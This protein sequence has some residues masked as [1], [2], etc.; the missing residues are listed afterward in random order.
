M[1]YADDEKRA[2]QD[3]KA[4][5]VIRESTSPW[6]SPIVLV[7]MKDGGLR[8]CVDNHKVDELDKPDRFLLP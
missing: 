6:A 4:K 2:I 3:L 7:K 5:G 8:P 1:A